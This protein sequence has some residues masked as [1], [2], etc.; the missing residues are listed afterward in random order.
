MEE[1]ITQVRWMS[2]LNIVLGA[3]VLISPWALNFTT[4][5]S[6]VN[7]VI[8]GAA[9][10]IMDLIREAAPRLNWS[11][12]INFLVG[13]WLVV[14]PFILQL[15]GAAAYLNLIIIGAIITV[16]SYANASTEVSHS[17]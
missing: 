3:W 2:G 6:K 14:S 9:I 15:N 1:R 11:S 8:F 10:I 13:I 5:A 16:N 4:S 12:W 7:S 17:T